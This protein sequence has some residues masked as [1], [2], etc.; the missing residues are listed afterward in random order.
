MQKIIAEIHLGNVR[1]NAEYFK[2]VTGAKLCAVVKAN[3]YGHGA[4]EITLAL[5]SV[6][7]CFAVA[8][9]DEGVA[10]RTAACGKDV[11]VFSPPLTEEEGYQIL[12][13]GFI[14]TVPDLWTAKLICRVCE[15]YCL[16]AKQPPSAPLAAE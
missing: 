5:S 16:T 9:V 15:K 2:R 8:L 10:I 12:A 6:A 11:L 14:A 13:N 1:R 4:E 7:D 3:A